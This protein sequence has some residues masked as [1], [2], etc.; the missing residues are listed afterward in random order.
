MSRKSKHKSVARRSLSDKRK[1]FCL[2]ITGSKLHFIANKRK[3]RRGERDFEFIFVAR[4]F[5]TFD[6]FLIEK[7]DV[8]GVSVLPSS[9][10][11]AHRN[12]L[13]SKRWVSVSTTNLNLTP[14]CSTFSRELTFEVDGNCRNIFSVRRC[15]GN[16]YVCRRKPERRGS[17]KGFTFGSMT[18]MFARFVHFNV[19]ND[20][21]IFFGRLPSH[22][23]S[24]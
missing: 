24:W 17:S 15:G 21:T 22:E 11:T 9:V 12:F 5:M 19:C 6:W 4:L 8:K 16:F 7:L 23:L 14:S 18:T 13:T 10:S 1:S 3:A 20:S 2:P